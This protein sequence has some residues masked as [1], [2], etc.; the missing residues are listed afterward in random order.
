MHAMPDR[1]PPT[2]PRRIAVIVVHGVGDQQPFESA[3]AIGDL[4][5]NID[6]DMT[7]LDH[8]PAPCASP[9]SEVAPRY[10]P[11]LERTF[12]INVRPVVIRDA[13]EP[14]QDAGARGPFHRWVDTQRQTPDKATDDAAW[15]AFMRGQLR[16]YHGDGP[17]ETYETIRLEGRRHG[18][19]QLVHIYEAYWADLSRLKAGVFSIFTELYQLLFHLSS[20]GTHV[21]DAESLHHQHPSW[22]ALRRWQNAASLWLTVQIAIVNLFMLGAALVAVGLLGVRPLRPAVQ[23][24]IVVCAIATL[25]VAWWG[26]ALWRGRNAA[27]KAWIAPVITWGAVAGAAWLTMTFACDSEGQRWQYGGARCDPILRPTRFLSG[28]LLTAIAGALTWLIV[29]AYDKRRPGAARTAVKYA[30]ILGGLFAVSLLYPRLPD[31]KD[32]AVSAAFRAFALLYISMMV[33]WGVFFLHASAAWWAGRQALRNVATPPQDDRPA[34]S[35][36]TGR[37]MLGL[38]A[39]A[40]ASV[41]LAGWGVIQIGITRMLDPVRDP[42]AYRALLP[43]FS[44]HTVADLM[45]NIGDYGGSVAL[46]VLLAAGGITALPAV[47]G[48]APVVWAEV[49]P[50]DF[51]EARDADYA[52]RLGDWLTVTYRGLRVSGRILYA[53]M[54]FVVPI[55][56][57][58]LLA[59][60]VVSMVVPGAGDAGRHVR[61]VLTDFKILGSVSA[62]L[63]AWLFAA[64]GQ[65]KK[66]A[67]GFRTVLEILL[68]VDNWLREHPL[69]SNPKARICGRYVSLL[70]YICNWRDPLA[71]ARGYDGIVVIAHSQGTVITAD[72]LRFLFWESG[73]T[74]AGYDDQLAPLDTR[75]VTLFTMGCPLRDLYALRFP[76]LYSWARHDDPAPMAAWT[77]NDL[78]TGRTSVDP[79]P[80]ELGITTW[81]NAYRSGD[82]IGRFLWRT[83]PC[84]YLWASDRCGVAFDQPAVSVSSDGTTRMEFCIGAGAHTHYWDRTAPT[85][86]MELDRLIGR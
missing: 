45:R 70:R 14:A 1:P 81:V 73:G 35:C 23:V 38:P 61:A 12:R 15:Y 39:F 18:P 66:A 4:L 64:R 34:R 84:G 16:C 74:L 8:R 82:Y 63:L 65:F 29:R 24:E 58:L 69:N 53:T 55:L 72:L 76:R 41:T 56:V 6:M 85:I 71:P 60:Y 33:A 13:D 5:Q 80:A 25:G 9:P 43:F 51:W 11:F 75:P 3:R 7:V 52:A 48:L 67:L 19:E 49:Q 42:L 46:P 50:P 28:V 32:R 47:W 78:A 54:I 10:D 62:A 68:D 57:A 27:V 20:L 44:A 2:D 21:V 30:A 26:R 79:N 40:F 77:A 22:S 17:E 86:A 37:L 31:S 59:A 36:W 83:T